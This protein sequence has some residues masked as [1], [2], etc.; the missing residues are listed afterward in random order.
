MR[1]LAIAGLTVAI[2]VAAAAPAL[3]RQDR[4]GGHGRARGR[5]RATP[6]A[7]RPYADRF[8]PAAAICSLTPERSSCRSRSLR[9]AGGADATRRPIGAESG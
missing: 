3:A 7:D 5:R 1:R 4:D 9:R 8:D 6:A 2:L